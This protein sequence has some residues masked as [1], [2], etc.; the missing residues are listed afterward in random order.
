MY[1]HRDTKGFTLIE[2]LVVIAIIGIL[3]SM[4]LPTLQ[5]ARERARGIRCMVNLKQIFTAMVEYGNDYDDYICPFWDGVTHSWEELLK[6]YVKSGKDV[7]YYTKNE[8]GK[9][10]YYDYMLFF[11]PTRFAQGQQK[12]NSGY[13]T[14]YTVNGHVMSWD[15]AKKAPDPWNPNANTNVAR[16]RRFSEF[17][18]HD[19]IGMIF[20]GGGWV[21]GTPSHVHDW[22]QFVHN[23]NTNILFLSGD[24]RSVRHNSRVPVRFFD[25]DPAFD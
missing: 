23:D 22:C 11:C 21:W 12:S 4:L 9:W 17:K 6:P 7:G 16:T 19:E 24:V 1:N 18:Y 25:E 15:E 2:L 13:Q 8:H 5:K 14:N 10:Y 3:A 20:E